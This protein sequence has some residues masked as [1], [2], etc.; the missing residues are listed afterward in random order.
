MR[1]FQAF[2]TIFLFASCDVGKSFVGP[3]VTNI[4]TFQ[5]FNPQGPITTTPTGWFD[6]YAHEYGVVTDWH[7][8]T[9]DS[10]W[11]AISECLDNIDPNVLRLRGY[12]ILLLEDSVNCQCIEVAGCQYFYNNQGGHISVIGGSFDF[13]P[14]NPNASRGPEREFT[15]LWRHEMIHLALGLQ[16]AGDVNPD[17]TRP[18]WECQYPIGHPG[19]G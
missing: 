14:H 11:L 15:R 19:G 3:D 9:A 5:S 17:H 12:P 7:I 8:Q 13:D 10:A 1:V 16:N 6:I 4:T 2:L 18:E